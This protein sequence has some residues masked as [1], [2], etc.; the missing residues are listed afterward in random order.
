MEDSFVDFS[1]KK[2]ITLKKDLKKTV[3]DTAYNNWLKQLSFISHDENIITLSV[4]TKFLRDY[5]SVD[6]TLG[7]FQSNF[8]V[9]NQ[10]GKTILGKKVKKIVQ[11]GRS[12]YYCPGLQKI[13]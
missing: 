7:N 1:E 12:T 9:Y 13:K 8:Q 6:G 5:V 2:W 10:E 4:P 11:Y 3:G